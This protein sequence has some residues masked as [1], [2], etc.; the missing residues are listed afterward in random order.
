MENLRVQDIR[1][2]K[3]KFREEALSARDGL[4]SDLRSRKSERIMQRLLRLPVA[5]SLAAWFVYVSF[6]S[7]VETAPLIRHL[8]AEGRRV[9]VPC[10]DRA[11]KAMTASLLLDPGRDLA[12]G[13]MGINEPVSGCYRPVPAGR[14]D[15]V[16]VPGAAFSGNG[17][18][19]GYGGG[20]YDRFLR[21][22]CAVTIGLAFDLQV[23]DTLPQDPARDVPLDIIV[24]ESRTMDCAALRITPA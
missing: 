15:I 13:S 24:T 5:G 12:P 2:L 11:S 18:R 3:K 19:I 23:F 1:L 20:Y 17:G 14:I 10:V 9:S 22:C 7:E 16:I 6:R 4:S 21:S 8:L